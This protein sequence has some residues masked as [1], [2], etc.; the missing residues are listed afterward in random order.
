M[1]DQQQDLMKRK[2]FIFCLNKYCEDVEVSS[3]GIT[4]LYQGEHKVIIRRTVQKGKFRFNYNYI[5]ILQSS[6]FYLY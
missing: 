2:V 6:N 3:R 5:I 4:S 1:E